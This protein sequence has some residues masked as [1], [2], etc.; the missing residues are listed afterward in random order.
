MA[1]QS[2][3]KEIEGGKEKSKRRFDSR[4]WTHI[5]QYIVEECDSRKNA[6]VE[7]DNAMKEIDRQLRMEPDIRHKLDASGKPDPDR[8]WMPETELPL[9]AETLEML[10]ADARRMEM[11]DSG[12]WFES[13]AALT[14]D[15]L[16]RV[17]LQSLVT[18]DRNEVPSKIDQ[19]NANKLASGF[20]DH[21]H[22]QYDFASNL[23]LI[24]A[25]A[26]KYGVGIGR[27][28]LVTKQVFMQTARGVTKE[29]QKIP[30][31]IPRSIKHTYLDQSPHALMHEGFFIGPATIFEKF[32][33]YE[34]LVIA[35]SRGSSDPKKEDGGWMPKNLKGL[36][37]NDK[38]D[39]RLIEFEGDLVV[40][41]KTSG[42]HYIPGAIVTVAVGND[43]SKEKKSFQAVVRFRFRKYP[44]SSYL[45]FPYHQ[46]H[47]DTPYGTSPLLK[48]W[49]IQKAAVDALNRVMMSGALRTAPPTSYDRDDMNFAQTGGPRIHPFAQWA[50]TGEIKVHAD[51]GGDPEAMFQIYVGLLQ[52]YSNVTGITA[53]RL[54]Q[55][56]LSHTTRFAK[57]AELARGVV[58]TVDYVKASLKGPLTQ[59]LYMAYRMGR[60]SMKEVDVFLEPYGGFVTVKKDHLPDEVA[61]V[62]HG[63]GGPQEEEAKT[64][65]ML[66]GIQLAMGL[67]QF[68]GQAAI[69][70]AQTGMRSHVNIEAAQ[71]HI[72]RTSG[73]TDLDALIRRDDET[74]AP[75]I[76]G[77]T[78]EPSGMGADP[79]GTVP[80][81]P[82]AALQ[83]FPQ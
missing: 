55:Q 69:L 64:A 50:S 52:Q 59:W 47:L 42:S 24:N 14:D 80:I 78:P 12:L 38:K 22:R 61:F 37:P 39:I 45:V 40:P 60:D 75:S 3:V 58:R 29:T 4:D 68:R 30:V 62:A 16:D 27:A 5:A 57:E 44:F 13:H 32:Q 6:R 9:Q 11:P 51:V 48:G 19:D 82:G 1:S 73:W 76:P 79:E 10:V 70:E 25:E 21:L 53:P 35:A 17:D 65:R 36:H 66:Q 15:Y 18:G 54:G 41:R 31:L 77:G 46:E 23:D 49:P 28:R 72:L 74:R 43:G 8:A 7:L 20:L 67:E 81:S 2:D 26:F 56:T 63:A 71:E 34:D 83:T 33:K